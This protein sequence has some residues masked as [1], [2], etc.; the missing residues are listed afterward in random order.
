[1]RRFG[2]LLLALA[3]CG[4]DP[5]GGDRRPDGAR[6]LLDGALDATDAVALDGA[7]AERAP[8][9]APVGDAPG[10]D[11]EAPR[12]AAVDT[13]PEATLDGGATLDGA[14]DGAGDGALDAPSGDTTTRGAVLYPATQTHAPLTPELV[15]GLR[16]IAA[17]GPTLDDHVVSRV[18]ASN[19]VNTNFL[20]CFAGSNVDLAGR[21][22]L[23][24]TLDFVREGRV[25]GASALTRTSLAATVGWSAFAVLQG[26]PSAL[27]R[28]VDTA[29]PRMATVLFGT[30]DIGF[31]DLPRYGANLLDIADQL[32]ARGVVPI[33]TSI[34]PRDD[35]AAADL[36][37]PRYVSVM[38]VVAQAR[39]LP[40]VDLERSLRM[41]PTHGLGS[42]GI[43][44]NVYTQGGAARGCVFTPEGLRYGHNQRN[45]FTLEAFQRVL[46]ALRD[47]RAPDREAPR[48]SGSGTPS[49]PYE[50]TSLP[51]GDLRNTATGGV[52]ALGRYPGCMSA[53]DEGGAEYYY[54]LRVDR[55]TRLRA[56]VVTRGTTDVDVHLMD[57]SLRP[58][59]CVA[60]DDRVVTREVPA[61][62][63]HL[64]LDTYVS[65]GVERAGEYLL[66]VLQDP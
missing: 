60:R 29:R 52:R 62:T 41:L 46:G 55:P 36:W 32:T 48:L 58:E 45:L 59:G 40:F 7:T 5:A 61:G 30:N 16:A 57:A 47:G 23:R 11:R 43:H 14:T 56:V 64:V 38:R 31:R 13:A 27:T 53:A 39:G 4:E 49:E 44:L 63:W 8:P 21:D 34:P 51:F 2:A 37:V 6:A 17:R 20:S 50:I 54:R 66:V 65:G 19:S 42:D 26:T 25:A 22:A 33:F 15:E 35:S 1:M 10:P 28:E 3:G 24:P 18:G 9:D 12:D